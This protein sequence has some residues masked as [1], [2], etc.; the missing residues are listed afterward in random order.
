MENNTEFTSTPTN[1]A[2]LAS[3]EILSMNKAVLFSK[4]ECN[5][6]V[7]SCID[8]LYLDTRVVGTDPIH[9]AKRQK[10]RGEVN[11]FPFENIR[12]VTK[13]ANDEIYDFKLLGIIDQD[14]PQVYQ[15]SVEDYYNWHIDI[16]PMA[17]TRKLTF[18]I[19]LSDPTE[20]T[21]GDVEFLNT[22]TTNSN[23]SEQGAL[24]VFPAFLPYRIKEVTSGCKRIIVGHIHGAVFR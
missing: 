14:F 2:K 23:I 13:Q 3:L 10:L 20:Y 17:S 15:Y 5:T 7:E 19:N 11:N 8:D 1:V 4:E 18:I 9:R 12:A 21:G 22:D 16:N 6:I 24:L